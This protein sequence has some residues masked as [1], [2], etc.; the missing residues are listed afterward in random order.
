MIFMESHFEFSC[1]KRDSQITILESI[2]LGVRKYS[3]KQRAV[4]HIHDWRHHMLSSFFRH[5]FKNENWYL[6]FMSSQKNW[7]RYYC[8]MHVC[9]FSVHEC[10]IKNILRKLARKS[11]KRNTESI[12]KGNNKHEYKTSHSSFLILLTSSHIFEQ[13][14]SGW[15]SLKKSHFLN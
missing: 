3:C 1:Q 4:F 13:N 11:L 14:Y 10:L 15:K 5:L 2:T 7:R 12:Q 6:S 8:C 9:V